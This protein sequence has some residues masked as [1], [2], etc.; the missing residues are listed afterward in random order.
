MKRGDERMV[1][2]RRGEAEMEGDEAR[3]GLPER[4]PPAT[5]RE[6]L[7]RRVPSTSPSRAAL[8]TVHERLALATTRMES[9]GDGGRYGVALAM[10]ALLEY[11]AGVGLP[12]ATLAPLEAVMAAIVDARRGKQSDIFKPDRKRRGGA[13]PTSANQLTFE[14]HLAVIADCCVRHVRAAG[15]R[16]FLERGCQ[17]A[18]KLIRRSRWHVKPTATELR[19]LRERAKVRGK[20]WPDGMVFELFTDSQM[21][22]DHPLEWAR[23]LLKHDWVN[24]LPR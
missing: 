22:R 12:Y 10:H 15:E 24:Q 4:L 2:D 5:I 20:E 16:P 8:A 6:G 18:E 23:M 3:G 14:G 17:L 19:E 11:F 21:C 13:P 9:V 7:L 1:K